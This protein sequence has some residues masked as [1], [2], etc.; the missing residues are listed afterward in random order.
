MAENNGMSQFLQKLKELPGKIARKF[1]KGAVAVKE[2]AIHRT[3]REV[4]LYRRLMKILPAAAGAIAALAVVG[5]VAAMMYS[6]YGSFTVT[7]NNFDN[8][9]YALSLSEYPEFNEATARLNADAIKDIDCMR[10]ADVP[11]HLDDWDN[12]NNSKGN[13]LAYSFYVKNAGRETVDVNYELFIRGATLGIER[14]VRVRLYT[15]ETGNRSYTD[16]AYPKTSGG[17][18]EEGTKIFKTDS[19][20]TTGQIL[21]MKTGD[22][23]KFTVVIWIEGDDPDANDDI[24][25]GQFKI[26]MNLSVDGVNE[27]GESITA[28]ESEEMTQPAAE[29][30]AEG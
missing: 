28:V 16:Y 25:G 20:I 30:T 3:A 7:V 24:L 18:P 26:D 8:V 6:K 27:Y 19:T 23:Y 13:Y 21:Q 15:G 29:S 14:A 4:K 11:G 10:T 12:P 9:Q 5:Y 1:K 22:I 2:T 17:G